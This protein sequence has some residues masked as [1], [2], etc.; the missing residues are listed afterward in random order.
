MNSGL[1]DR[2]WLQATESAAAW[3]KRLDAPMT[4]WS[5]V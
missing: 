3:A 5:K 4:N 1:Y 2:P